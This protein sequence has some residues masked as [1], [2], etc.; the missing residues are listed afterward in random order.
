V[1][2]AEGSAGVLSAEVLVEV[3]VGFFFEVAAAAVAVNANTRQPNSIV[4]INFFISF[5]SF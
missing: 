4:I 1:V 5:T 2:S 3:S